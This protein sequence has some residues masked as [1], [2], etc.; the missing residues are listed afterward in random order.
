[1]S[2]VLYGVTLSPFVKKV[3]TVLK[4]KNIDFEL[5]PVSPMEFPDNYEEIHPLKEIPA[6][7]DEDIVIPDSSVICDYL[8]NKYPDI[9]VYPRSIKKRA[10]ALWLE[11]YSDTK[12]CELLA[13][14]FLF[15]K[16][17]KPNFLNIETDIDHVND[18][19]ENELPPAMDYLEKNISGDFIFG[20][21]ITVADISIAAHFLN[22][23][24]IGFCIDIDKYPKLSSLLDNV[25]QTKGFIDCI[26]LDK[27]LM[28]QFQQ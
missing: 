24:Y 23:E 19:I 15:E 26:E 3:Y 1:M 12:L 7:I 14:G 2:K 9:G 18:I 21:E 11:E 25:C 6:F 5:N 28:K 22:A 13:K 8:E 4:L 10:K 16:F 27:A 20:D 17:V